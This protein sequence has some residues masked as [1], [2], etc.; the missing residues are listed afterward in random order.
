MRNTESTQ[1]RTCSVWDCH[2]PIARY[3]D[4]CCSGHGGGPGATTHPTDPFVKMMAEV[5]ALVEAARPFANM[6]AD[7]PNVAALRAAL[8]PFNREY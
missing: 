6:Q 4:H 8:E 7:S 1:R 3:S 5:Q 2:E